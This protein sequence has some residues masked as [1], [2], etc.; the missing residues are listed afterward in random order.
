M[1]RNGSRS[2]GWLVV[3]AV[4]V[5]VVVVA[6]IIIKKNK[7]SSRSCCSRTV[8]VAHNYMQLHI[9]VACVYVWDIIFSMAQLHHHPAA[10]PAVSNLK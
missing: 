2:R 4:V 9:P 1:G 8:V 7:N 3:V 10:N 5:V 6:T